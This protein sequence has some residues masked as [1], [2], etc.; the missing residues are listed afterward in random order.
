MN[1]NKKK[2]LAA[3]TLKIGKERIIFV[4]SRLDE[5]KEAITKQDIRDLMKDKAIVIK[6]IKGRR[7]K[8]K[9][10]KRS[11]GN[12]RKKVQTRKKDYVILTRKL[13]T[14]VKELKEQGK[15]SLEELRDIRKKIRN[16]EFRSKANL[17][18][19]VGGLRRWGLQKKEEEKERQIT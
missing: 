19:Y 15:I 18:E 11:P 2:E 12:I 5:I 10:R 7:K 8:Q 13:R 6:E 3:R 9:K 14:Y 16:K 17:R 1:L 4:K